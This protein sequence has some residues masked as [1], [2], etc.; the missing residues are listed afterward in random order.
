MEIVEFVHGDALI[1][2]PF[3]WI[4]GAILK[5][6]PRI[7]NWLIPW[8]LLIISII[9]SSILMSFTMDSIIQGVISTGV[10]VFGHE[11]FKETVQK[12]KK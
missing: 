9:S 6:T 7:H 5:K 8:I 12:R 4:I 11:L 10:A 3:L 2:V 1:L